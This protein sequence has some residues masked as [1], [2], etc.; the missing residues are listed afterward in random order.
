LIHLER[1]EHVAEVYWRAQMIGTVNRIPREAQAR[2]IALREKY[3]D[4]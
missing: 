1:L 4:G 2:L 3:S